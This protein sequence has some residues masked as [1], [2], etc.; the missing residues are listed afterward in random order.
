MN[1]TALVRGVW[2]YRGFVSSAVRSEFRSRY[3]R[4]RIGLAWMVL[5]PLFLVAIFTVV[6][7]EVLA[8]R[9]PGIDN[10]FGFAAYLLVGIMAWSLFAELTQ[11]LSTVFIDNASL[12]K[13]LSVP[14]A[15]L[16]M[17][18]FG[19]VAVTHLILLLVLLVALPLLGFAPT[20]HW[21]W[22]PLLSSVTA[23]FALGLGVLLGTLNVFMRDVGQVLGVV[24]QLGF[25]MTP[26]VYHPSML[27]AALEPWVVL[28]PMATMVVAYHNVLLFGV[29][30]GWGVAIL[31]LLA[32]GLNFLAWFMF[33]RAAADVVDVL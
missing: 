24:L 19:S 32:L 13:K 1:A 4:S 28:N 2:Q 12:L 14:R 16:P 6:L 27:P 25:W 31:A 21:L 33:R 18:A 10:V 20:L 11:R 22:L 9:M 7:S 30:P 17:I 29:A 3:A 5:H 8:A 23:A 26:I 15:S